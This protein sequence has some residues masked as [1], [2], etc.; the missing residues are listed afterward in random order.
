MTKERFGPK[1][2]TLAAAILASPHLAEDVQAL[3]IESSA[4]WE[5]GVTAIQE[6]VLHEPNEHSFLFLSDGDESK[7]IRGTE[8]TP[9]Q[10]TISI[11]TYQLSAALNAQGG[12]SAKLCIGHTH[13]PVLE[14]KGSLPEQ[15]AEKWQ[16]IPLLPSAADIKSVIDT[17]RSFSEYGV[18]P[19][20]LAHVAV[21]A[22]GLW[23]YDSVRRSDMTD[24]EFSA[25]KQYAWQ[26]EGEA[27]LEEAI[28]EFVREASFMD[29][30][31]D[32]RSLKEYEEVRRAYREN[33]GA[34]IRFVPYGDVSGEAS[35]TGARLHY[36]AGVESEKHQ[37]TGAPMNRDEPQQNST[38]STASD[39]QEVSN[40]QSGRLDPHVRPVRNFTVKTRTDSGGDR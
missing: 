30:G 27:R 15:H 14:F 24:A 22:R 3:E 19:D 20:S 25:A 40:T 34:E 26:P 35:C 39:Q 1:V 9:G 13:P 38:P 31:E 18:S 17:N 23:Y 33:L 32:P 29:I 21:D 2:L 6:S 5:Q 37:E 11:N 16:Y 12:G 10:T 4:S 8:G 36:A 28:R 7:W